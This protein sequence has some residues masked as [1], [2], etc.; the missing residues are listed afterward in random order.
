MAGN[1]VVNRLVDGHIQAKLLVGAVSDSCELEADQVA[2]TVGQML[3][4]PTTAPVANAAV[5]RSAAVVGAEGGAVDGDVQAEIKRARGG[6]RP[7]DRSTR[8][9]MESAFSADFRAVRVH[10]GPEVDGLNDNLQSR[11]FT[12]GSDIFVRRADFAPGSRAGDELLAHELTHTV[13][14]GASPSSQPVSRK[15][16]TVQR[17]GSP[18]PAAPDPMQALPPAAQ[19]EEALAAA[20]QQEEALAAAFR[21]SIFYYGTVGGATKLKD[22]AEKFGEILG[23]T[24][25]RN[26]KVKEAAEK[27]KM[28]GA[29]GRSKAAAAV[30]PSP[31][32]PAKK[33]GAHRPGDH[34]LAPIYYAGERFKAFQ[35]QRGEG[36]QDA[37]MMDM[38][39]GKEGTAMHGMRN[40][41]IG[42]Y[43]HKGMG[44]AGEYDQMKS[45]REAYMETYSTGARAGR[46]GWEKQTAEK[47]AAMFGEKGDLTGT[48]QISKLI[49]DGITK[50]G[51][52]LVFEGKYVT[53]EGNFVPGAFKGDTNMEAIALFPLFAA[54]P[55][56]SRV[57]FGNGQLVFHW[58]G[59][60]RYPEQELFTQNWLYNK[61]FEMSQLKAVPRSSIFWKFPGP[62]AHVKDLW[63]GV[64]AQQV[65]DHPTWIKEST[66]SHVFGSYKR[67]MQLQRIDSALKQFDVA[68]GWLADGQ[69]PKDVQVAKFDAS[70]KELLDAIN[71]WQALKKG[72]KD[73]VV[74][75]QA[76]I[77]ADLH[78]QVSSLQD[79]WRLFKAKKRA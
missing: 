31:G 67:S 22:A 66:R 75:K 1:E 64:K 27:F 47:P 56:A 28:V 36:V 13:Q 26:I 51:G 41:A 6:G 11:A 79:Q 29:R 14:Q 62:Y 74:S 4:S 15:F 72:R 30:A 19:P 61:P 18:P 48:M 60:E 59:K 70:I 10:T 42:K 8:T 24:R 9:R 3:R 20:Q 17:N 58:G 63:E 2:Q 73:A 5:A 55:G 32:G 50:Y 21:S 44:Y 46:E 25:L 23:G 12:L 76:D 54:Q 65:M 78:Q 38:Y 49:R 39:Y 57:P 40:P 16:G 37:Q 53:N 7:L 77:V 45:G 35:G 69:L 52:T 34:P 33:G 71:D 43:V 68:R